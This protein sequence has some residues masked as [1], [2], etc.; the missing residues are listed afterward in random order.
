[1]CRQYP[2]GL[3]YRKYRDLIARDSQAK[4]FRWGTMQRVGDVYAMGKVRHPDHKTVVL[5]FWHQVLMSEEPGAQGA[6][7]VFLD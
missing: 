7:I 3:T 1:M 6:N 4:H 2:D 5:P